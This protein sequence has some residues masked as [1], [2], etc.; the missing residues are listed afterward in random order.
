MDILVIGSQ[1]FIGRHCV[2]YF[3]DRGHQV[4]HADIVEANLPHYY[5]LSRYNTSF[6]SLFNNKNFDFCIN[7][8]GSAN[9]GFSFDHP[10]IDFE[11]NVINVHKIL[12]AIRTFNPLCKFVNFSSAAV[13]GNPE[14]LPIQENQ[15]KNPL[16]PYGFHKLQSEY[17][18][19]EYNRFFGIGTASLRIFSAY[20]PGLKKQL[21]WDLF[22]KTQN[23]NNIELF[24]S[25]NETRDFIYIEDLL[26]AIE[27][28]ILNSPF[29]G[30]CYNVASGFEIKIKDAVMTFFNHFDSSIKL[31]FTG[32][33]KIGDPDHW[34]ADISNLKS[35]GYA[36]LWTLNAGLKETSEWM[37]SINA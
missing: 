7:A 32:K 34:V 13:Y 28:V 9:V 8:S 2:Q 12:V 31:A 1:G 37:K 30:E 29:N 17:I 15:T 21:F 6:D 22:Q 5:C 16:S 33:Q 4:S 23:S 36:P 3:A 11:L 24:G 25:G 14:S 26:K 35:L 20:G 27:L 18:L 10:N 19:K